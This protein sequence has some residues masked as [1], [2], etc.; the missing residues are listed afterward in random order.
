MLS[1]GTCTGYMARHRVLD[2]TRGVWLRQD[3]LG[4]VDGMSLYAVLGGNP[5]IHRDPSGLCKL[6]QKTNDVKIATIVGV[7]SVGQC[8]V[9]VQNCCG[10]ECNVTKSCTGWGPY[11]V[12][13]TGECKL[14]KCSDYGGPTPKKGQRCSCEF[15]IEVKVLGGS[16]FGWNSKNWWFDCPCNP[17]TT[18]K[19]GSAPVPP[20]D[21][22]TNTTPVPPMPGAPETGPT[23]GGCGSP[24]PT[25][26]GGG[27][28]GPPPLKYPKTPVYDGF[29]PKP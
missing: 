22:G 23:D 28:G 26:G 17:C 18:S 4:Y 7:I 11:S 3:P 1:G 9:S 15:V 10:S 19:G 14:E 25:G 21:G 5:I 20:S 27:C 12:S 29:L 16:W 6:C 24:P 13:M 8:W 2:S